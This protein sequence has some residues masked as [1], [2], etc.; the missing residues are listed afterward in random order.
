MDEIKNEPTDADRVARSLARK[1][2][3]TTGRDHTSKY[4]GSRKSSID[5]T[6]TNN[7]A[8]VF[9]LEN[10]YKLGPDEN[11]RFFAYKLQPN[12]QELISD[13][14][15]TC[16]R[17]NPNGYNPKAVSSLARELADSIRREAKNMGTPRYKVVVHVVAGENNEQDVR[18]GSRCL[19]NMELDNCV[20]VTNK[21]KHIWVSAVIYV[22][23]A[24]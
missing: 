19:W 15:D 3:E 4:S 8:N 17:N 5:T 9:R 1:R 16:E 12:I 11:K 14:M 18:V 23:Y 20:S 7:R 22:L 24:E 21:T 2:G 6:N 13:K 10:T